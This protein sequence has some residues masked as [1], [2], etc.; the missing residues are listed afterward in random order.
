LPFDAILKEGSESKK[1]QK[2]EMAAIHAQT[3]VYERLRTRQRKARCSA[4]PYFEGRMMVQ[5]F[6]PRDDPRTH[7]GGS[8]RH[9]SGLAGGGRSSMP[10]SA[11]R[12]PKAFCPAACSGATASPTGG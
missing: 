1:R 8:L 11:A 3:F 6:D 12:S 10:T 5:M 9:Q 4:I 2:S 7:V